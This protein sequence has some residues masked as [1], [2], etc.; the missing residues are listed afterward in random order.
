VGR[1]TIGL[2]VSRQTNSPTAVLDGQVELAQ[3]KHLYPRLVGAG[4]SLS[5]QGGGGMGVQHLS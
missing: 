1:L 3:L 2:S 4:L 5:R